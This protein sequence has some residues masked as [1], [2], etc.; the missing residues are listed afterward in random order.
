[1]F[2][3]VYNWKRKLLRLLTII[4]LVAAFAA[5]FPSLSGVFLKQ[6]PVFN[7]WFKDEQPSGNPMRVENE[8]NSSK[9]EQ[10]LDRFVF[11]LQDF[12]AKE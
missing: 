9:F 1:M 4:L 7:S 10:V 3:V 11:K 2:I 5:A 12:Y 6:V 8:N